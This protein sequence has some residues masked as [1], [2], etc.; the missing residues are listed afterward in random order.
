MSPRKITGVLILVTFLAHAGLAG[1][2]FGIGKSGNVEVGSPTPEFS[3]TDLEKNLIQYSAYRGNSVVLLDFWSIY[4]ASCVE[5]MPHLIE[6]YNDL[7]DQ[8]LV[9]LG[10]NLDSFGTRRVMRFINGL[11]YTIPYP[12]I[13][14][15]KRNIAMAF[16][17]MVLPTTIVIDAGGKIRMYHVGYKKGDEKEIRKV[18]ESSLQKLKRAEKTK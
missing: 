3:G 18:I 16:N 4:C 6:I 1:A 14:D 8:G 10:I 12:V 7:K 11:E 17:A 13:I 2:F 5:E 15:K 9:V